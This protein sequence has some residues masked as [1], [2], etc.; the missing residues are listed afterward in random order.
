ML[1]T[2]IKA[3]T[4]IQQFKLSQSVPVVVDFKVVCFA[5]VS[6]VDS[7]IVDLAVAVAAVGIVIDTVVVF[8]SDIAVT[9]VAVSFVINRADDVISVIVAI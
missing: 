2:S 5:V 7:N 1:I 6:A 3:I 4:S 9:C 8:V